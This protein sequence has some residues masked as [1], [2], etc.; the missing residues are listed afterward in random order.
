M[1]PEI[2][3]DLDLALCIVEREI[4]IAQLTDMRIDMLPRRALTPTR[5]FTKYIDSGT[6]TFDLHGK[7]TPAIAACTPNS[8]GMARVALRFAQAVRHEAR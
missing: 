5:E 3:E 2:H 7:M 8:P 4:Q 6:K 1:R